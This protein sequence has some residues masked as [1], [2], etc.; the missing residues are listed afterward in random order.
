M[1]RQ[2]VHEQDELQ[3]QND[4]LLLLIQ[5]LVRHQFGRRSEQLTADQLTSGQPVRKEES[6]TVYEAEPQQ[7]LQPVPPA[8]PPSGPP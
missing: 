6:T 2:V 1:L 4:K 3:A 7:R 5:R 8:A